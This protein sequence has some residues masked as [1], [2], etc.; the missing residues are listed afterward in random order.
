MIPQISDVSV[1][2]EECRLLYKTTFHNQCH[3]L[4]FALYTPLEGIVH[5]KYN[6]GMNEI[7][8]GERRHST[9]CLLCQFSIYDS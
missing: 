9:L 1:E 3:M 2:S 6:Q 5:Q 8:Y 7:S 4:F